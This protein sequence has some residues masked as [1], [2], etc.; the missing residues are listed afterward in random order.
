MMSPAREGRVGVDAQE[1]YAGP[2][3]GGRIV[4]LISVRLPRYKSADTFLG[5]RI[6]LRINR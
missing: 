2:P 5:T 6:L 4:A 1:N 3:L